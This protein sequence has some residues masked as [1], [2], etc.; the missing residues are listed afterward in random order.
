MSIK[1]L[2][3]NI[4]SVRAVALHPCLCQRP[5]VAA[6]KRFEADVG[7]LWQK[8]RAYHSAYETPPL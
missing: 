3:K 1:T 2:F 8:Q 4:K 6:L 7:G 5:A